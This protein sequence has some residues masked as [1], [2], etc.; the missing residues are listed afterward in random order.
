MNMVI[1]TAELQE[2]ARSAT[3]SKAT[4]ESLRQQLTEQRQLVSNM[5]RRLRR[6]VLAK[7]WQGALT[8]EEA[9]AERQLCAELA[10]RLNEEQELLAAIQA[11]ARDSE[12]KVQDAGNR[13]QSIISQL[14][15]NHFGG[16]TIEGEMESL[17]AA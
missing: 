14:V 2:A 5:S 4:F 9:A 1:E 16:T 13:V 3:H 12:T 10:G 6:I 15:T 8:E 11:A 17:S 7:K